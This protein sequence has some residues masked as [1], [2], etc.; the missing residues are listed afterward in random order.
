MTIYNIEPRFMNQDGTISDKYP[1]QLKLNIA[2][3]ALLSEHNGFLESI[4][5]NIRYTDI[6]T[7]VKKLK[8]QSKHG[9][10]FTVY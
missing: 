7:L 4:G 8:G 1:S 6:N 5:T 9:Y 2:L 3:Y 10:S